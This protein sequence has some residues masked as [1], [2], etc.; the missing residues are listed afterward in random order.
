MSDGMDIDRP[1]PPPSRDPRIANRH[2]APPTTSPRIGPGS[3]E[4]QRNA[5]LA[6]PKPRPA[7]PPAAAGSPVMQPGGLP[8]ILLDSM[9][10]CVAIAMDNAMQDKL[11]QHNRKVDALLHKAKLSPGFR[12]TVEGFQAANE[13]GK[14]DLKDID[15]AKRKHESEWHRTS[16]ILEAALG[17]VVP[18][19]PNIEERIARLEN[20]YGEKL[21]NQRNEYEERLKSQAAQSGKAIAELQSQVTQAKSDINDINK[22]LDQTGSISQ[23]MTEGLQNVQDEFN[24]L[25]ASVRN[26]SA[27]LEQVKESVVPK[28]SP[29]PPPNGHSGNVSPELESK[30]NDM[31]SRLQSLEDAFAKYPQPSFD[32]DA[33]VKSLSEQIRSVQ[34]LLDMRN[35]V[36]GSEANELKNKMAQ[37]TEEVNKKL[38]Q[39]TEE[40]NRKL[41]QQTEE[42]NSLKAAHGHLSNEM[43]NMGNS[44]VHSNSTVSQNFNGLSVTI[45]RLQRINETIK[46]GLHSLETRYNNLSTEHV[47]KNMAAVMQEMYPSTAH[48]SEQVT[49]LNTSVDN[50]LS[51]FQSTIDQLAQAQNTGTGDVGRLRQEFGRLSESVKTLYDTCQTPL[52]KLP[53]QMDSLEKKTTDLE[54]SMDRNIK[55]LEDELR[56]KEKANSETMQKLDAQRDRTDIAVEW[57]ENHGK[58]MELMQQLPLA[59]QKVHSDNNALGRQVANVSRQLTSFVDDLDQVKG[60]SIE[61]NDLSHRVSRMEESST[62]KSGVKANTE[63]EK[64]Q[65]NDDSPLPSRE[66]AREGSQKPRNSSKSQDK[67]RV[68]ETQQKGDGNSTA[69]IAQMADTNPALALREKK[70]NKK[71][72]KRTLS[73]SPS[74]DGRASVQPSVGGSSISGSVADSSEKKKK[75]KKRKTQEGEAA[76]SG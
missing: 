7:I 75:K 8:Q 29:M 68:P 46:T 44:I 49:R 9:Q 24:A 56:A 39:E 16:K 45:D 42:L 2:N 57:I 23:K 6:S 19:T 41:A 28:A 59:I 48:L 64:S 1:G 11:Q 26:Q 17:S 54:Q 53:G 63:R 52:L 74:E 27:S 60:K 70:K 12:S 58:K 67:E 31:M 20:N 22:R 10:A 15:E 38:A 36:E 25:K 5:S 71:K 14:V 55:Q 21:M 61:L 65:T 76:P 32:V 18:Q 3:L 4:S 35:D 47:V 13:K 50:K 72:K 34:T 73:P 69:Y 30:I 62:A 37:Q 33:T 43:R 66:E 40:L 51:S